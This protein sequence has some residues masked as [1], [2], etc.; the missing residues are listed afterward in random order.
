MMQ[1]IKLSP[2]LIIYGLIIGATTA[3]LGW[4]RSNPYAFSNVIAEIALILAGIIAPYQQF[5]PV[6]RWLTYGLPY[7]RTMMR[8]F[9]PQ[10]PK[11]L[12][13]D[14]L[15]AILWLVIGVIVYTYKVHHI[16]KFQSRTMI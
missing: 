9:T 12:A 1:S 15:I 5:P 11:T 2:L 6:F 7:A 8:F 3:I 14:S 4:G 13:I 16:G 10:S